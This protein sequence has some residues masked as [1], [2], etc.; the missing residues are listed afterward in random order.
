MT[1]SR[2]RWNPRRTPDPKPIHVHEPVRPY[3]H[4]TSAT[5]T[6]TSYHSYHSRSRVH[7]LLHASHHSD[8]LVH[9]RLELFTAPVHP[10]DL[11]THLCEHVVHLGLCVA[12]FLVSDAHV[13]VPLFEVDPSRDLAVAD[14]L[15]ECEDAVDVT[16]QRRHVVALRRDFARHQDCRECLCAASHV[17]AYVC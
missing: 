6:T 3:L 1:K 12:R 13:Y 5:T 17:H 4:S 14:A 2:V 11:V 7:N 10:V 8:Q 15:A 16:L 9:H